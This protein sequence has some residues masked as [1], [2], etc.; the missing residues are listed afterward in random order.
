MGVNNNNNK[1][2]D[3]SFQQRINFDNGYTASVVCNEF[4][5][6]GEL[7]LYEIAVMHEGKIVYDTPVTD[8]VIGNLTQEG[9]EKVLWQIQ[10]LPKR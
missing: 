2:K 10:N 9:V 8:D 6:G 7:G 5:Y 3:M 1:E 4:S